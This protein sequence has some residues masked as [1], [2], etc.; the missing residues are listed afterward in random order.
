M[1][2][3]TDAL[4]PTFFSFF[5]FHC[6]RN[7]SSADLLAADPLSSTN[8]SHILHYQQSPSRQGVQH[9]IS[10]FTKMSAISFPFYST[11]MRRCST[12]IARFLES[13]NEEHKTSP[14]HILARR[15]L[16]L[17]EIRNTYLD[18]LPA[19][20]ADGEY[21][22]D[23]TPWMTP[24]VTKA[25]TACLAPPKTEGKRVKELYGLVKANDAESDCVPTVE[26][27]AMPRNIF[28]DTEK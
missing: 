13:H 17:S 21:T 10:S 8:Q 23:S 27:L 6:D 11:P 4:H 20:D 22:T 18:T 9:N 19:Y 3:V 1:E 14:R 25:I 5:F 2:T 12:N 7:S 28:P 15:F 16:S 24:P 26:C